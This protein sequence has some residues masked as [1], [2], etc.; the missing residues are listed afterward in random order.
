MPYTI[1]FE[2]HEG[3]IDEEPLSGDWKS[4]DDSIV[5]TNDVA[6]SGTQSVRIISANP[7]NI[8]SLR[9]DSSGS[10]IFFVDYYMQLTA[11][12][13]PVLPS[14]T[15]PETTAIIAVQPYLPDFGEWVFLDGDGDGRGVWRGSGEVMLLDG[16]GR[17]GWHRVTLRFNTTLNLW[18]AYVDG[19]LVAINLGFVETLSVGSEAINIYGNSIGVTYLDTFSL[20]TSNPL[21]TD[22][23]FDGIDDAF[24]MTH[25]LNNSEDDR[26]LDPDLDG[27]T[28]IEEYVYGIDPIVF[29][30]DEGVLNE[31]L[32]NR[33]AWYVD[34]VNGNDIKG[35]GS[36][37]YPFQTI[38]A[39][40]K[41]NV[42]HPDYL[43]NG[44]IIYLAGGNY[45]VGTLTEID[46]TGLSVEGT[47]DENGEPLTILGDVEISANNVTLKN[48][49]FHNS[50]LTLQS[51][52][53]AMIAN[54]VFSG[55]T[56]TSLSIF[57][58]S[59]NIISNNRFYSAI[60]SCV[61]IYWDSI[62]GN[63]SN[64]NQFIDNYFTNRP[65]ENTQQAIYVTWLSTDTNSISARNRFIN[66]AF[67]ETV[68]GRLGKVI[69]DSSTWW[70]V[71][72]YDYSIRFEDCYFK[73]ADRA[74]PFNEFVIIEDFPSFGWR[75]DELVNDAWVLS[76][77][78]YALTGNYN[79][80][81]HPPRVQ[82]TDS[83]GNGSIIET[84]HNAGLLPLVKTNNGPIISNPIV[85]LLIYQDSSSSTIDLY[86]VF[87]DI[88]TADS[89]LILTVSNSNQLL[90]DASI[91]N[92]I[93]TLNYVSGV[94]GS[95]TI[96]VT[97]TDGD[98][99]NPLSVSNTFKVEVAAKPVIQNRTDWY[100]DA[101]NGNDIYGTGDPS[102]PFQSL[103]HA[104][105]LNSQYPGFISAGDT[106]YLAPG[107]YGTSDNQNPITITFDTSD[108]SVQGTLDEFGKPLS[109]LSNVH[110]EAVANGFILANCEIL[111]GSLMLRNIEGAVI[112]NNSFT[113]TTPKWTLNTISDARSVALALLGA[114]NNTISNNQFSSATDTCVYL[115]WHDQDT[116]D[117]IGSDD[118]I[119]RF[120]YFTHH[121]NGTAEIIY[122]DWD[123]YGN[124]ASISN[125]NRFVE[126]AFE[127]SD[128]GL[129]TRVIHDTNYWWMG[130]TEGEFSLKF[131][132]CYFKRGDRSQAFSEFEIIVGRNDY[133][134]WDDLENDTWVS[135]NALAGNSS[136]VTALTG[137]YGNHEN[138]PRIRFVDG[139][140]DGL[141][142]AKS[143]L[144]G[145]VSPVEDSH[146]IDAL[147]PQPDFDLDGLK[148]N[149]D[150]DPKTALVWQ[151]PIITIN[152]AEFQIDNP[153]PHGVIA[154]AFNDNPI[155]LPG[156]AENHTSF[157]SGRVQGEGVQI[158]K[159][160]LFFNGYPVSEIFSK[161][162]DIVR[163]PTKFYSPDRT[164][165][166][167]SQTI[168]YGRHGT[169]AYDSEAV[170]TTDSS[171]LNQGYVEVGYGVL[172]S[173]SSF[174]ADYSTSSRIIYYG[175]K[176]YKLVGGGSITEY[177]YTYNRGG[178]LNTAGGPVEVGRGWI[179]SKNGFTPDTNIQSYKIYYGR[180]KFLKKTEPLYTSSPNRI[181]YVEVGRGWLTS[182]SG[183]IADVSGESRN[184]YYGAKD[185]GDVRVYLHTYN[186]SDLSSGGV[187]V[188]K[189]WLTSK[190]KFNADT[191]L[192][193]KRIYYGVRKFAHNKKEYLYTY[194]SLDV[195]GEISLGFGWLTS[196]NT[197]IPDTDKPSNRIYYTKYRHEYLYT[198]RRSGVEMGYGW[199][200]QNGFIADT[201][202]P[203]R[204]IYYGKAYFG[205][206][207]EYLY[208]PNPTDIVAEV[209][210]GRGWLTSKNRF[211]ADYSADPREVYY[212]M[213]SFGHYSRSLY[214]YNRHAFDDVAL[215][216][217]GWIESVNR[218]LNVD[219]ASSGEIDSD[220][221]GL[222]DVLEMQIGTSTT[223]SDT[224]FDG[225]SDS[226]EVNNY[227]TDPL[228]WDT[229][230][231]LLSDG[232]EA[233][234]SC[235]NPLAYDDPYALDST[236][237]LTL[238]KATQF[239]FDICNGDTDV[240][241][242]QLNDVL[243][244]TVYGT[245]VGDP[246]TDK[247]GLLDGV[248]LTY[249]LNP[250]IDDSMFDL[251]GDGY[252]N[253]FE[254][255]GVNGD[256]RD[257]AITPET[258]YLVSVD[259]SNGYGSIQAAIDDVTENYSII[260][261]KPGMYTGSGNFDFSIASDRPAVL[262]IAEEGAATTVLDGGQT[263]P[264]PSIFN[265][266]SAIVGFTIRNGAG[267]LDGGGLFIG[268]DHTSVAKCEIYGNSTIRNGA[269]I[270]VDASNVRI[271]NT[272]IY[273]NI[274]GSNGGGIYAN[275]RTSMEI[276]H[277]TVYNNTAPLGSEIYIS[278][279]PANDISMVNSIVW[280]ESVDAKVISGDI[281]S[282]S[283][284]IIK[285]TTGY[286]VND[287]WIINDDPLLTLEGRLN[288]DSI[289]IDRVLGSVS[290]DVD[291]QIRPYG[292]A[293]DI[294]AD[295][296]TGTVYGDGDTDSD[297]LRDWWE[298]F[299]FPG[300]DISSISPT[301]DPDKDGLV[302]RDELYLFSLPNLDDT[303]G[304]G[305][306]DGDEINRYG[307]D[308][309]STD[310]DGDSLSDGWEVTYGFNPGV[311]NPADADSDNDG[312]ADR[313][314]FQAGGNPLVEDT[315]GDGMSDRFE[316]E[317]GLNLALDDRELDKDNDGLSN[318][319]EFIT[320]T[321]A[322]YFDSDG[323]LLSDGWEVEHGLD[324]LIANDISADNDGDGID[325][326][327]EYQFG[328]NP[329]ASDTDG[330][331][332]SDGVEISQGSNANG[333]GDS[334]QAP[335]EDNLQEV[336]FSVGDPS[337]S[338]SERWEMNIQGLGP[339]TRQLKFSNREFGILG[340]N[341]FKLWK[342]TNYHITLTHIGSKGEQ[343]DYDWEAT[344]EG[345]PNTTVLGNSGTNSGSDRFTLVGNWIIDNKSGLLGV[346][347]QGFGS[348]NFAEGKEA[349]LLKVDLDIVHP[350]SGELEESKEDTNDGGYV[351]IKREVDGVDVAPVTHLKLHGNSLL[352]SDTKFRL[353]FADS[354]R[355]K[356]YS[357]AGRSTEIVSEQTE[358]AT[359]TD[360]TLY[361][362]G[363]GKSQSRGGEKLT[364]QIGING[365]WY[366][367]DTVKCTVVQSEFDIVNRVFIPYNWV[368]VPHPAH[369]IHVAEGDDRGYDPQLQGTFRVEQTVIICP[370]E[371][372]SSNRYKSVQATP[373]ITRHFYNSDVVNHT[374]AT[375]SGLEPVQPSYIMPGATVADGEEA[376]A[377]VS[378]V[379]VHLLPDSTSSNQTFVE[380]RGSAKE[381]IVAFAAPIDWRFNIG[382]N[383]NDP[384]NPKY[385]FSGIHDG[386]PAYE[387]Y[388]N[389]RLENFPVTEVLQWSPTLDKGVLELL[390]D[391]DTL[392]DT[393]GFTDIE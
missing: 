53:G 294:G 282:V 305:L 61:Y 116:G 289:A 371:D 291:G 347:N 302:N 13:L 88:E 121:F 68:S 380:L 128:R 285:G 4:T 159:Y 83:N 157:V 370:Y 241:D 259:S 251:D 6:H 101:T 313:F 383:I 43:N 286:S 284:C 9:F 275:D 217:T 299:Y 390:G 163:K 230:N 297:G 114:S 363:L 49:E 96:R 317:N 77:Y 365:N 102:L 108:L 320:G 142:L 374:G 377:D 64:D 50:D 366:D 388:I 98:A 52:T 237:G 32:Y 123:K 240:D 35:V 15:D 312:V 272:I 287:G 92:G 71:D 196:K 89:D 132:D 34:V 348:E 210:V 261:V 277:N 33:T 274:A 143:H 119:F 125:R 249:G 316:Y 262:V 298:T 310:S 149:F 63:T 345:L 301:D 356:I 184:I 66:C 392:T 271:E 18:D 379:T 23:D 247:D 239:G 269:G 95:A 252:P 369:A 161:S 41:L 304:D 243:E 73:R 117:D 129:L 246:D 329:F 144:A 226:E 72:A 59:N 227:K 192:K 65:S 311:G 238:L 120:N 167:G 314:E 343:P 174:T 28:N 152:G 165:L 182:K 181:N 86:D 229:D 26:N 122:V 45:D 333:S 79:D 389:G 361:F 283:N 29:N 391:A 30:A 335:S 386:F 124:L 322:N 303:D 168:Y 208:T 173:E 100:I 211:A 323:D 288:A 199:I 130:N 160:Q 106:I 85:D 250:L 177:I 256:V 16:L 307:T 10:T 376:Q 75:W 164:P 233:G 60:Y 110:I 337:G 278:A 207:I 235:L 135:E 315:D 21:F 326:F 118:N 384:I 306:N 93:L 255:K 276:V 309:L 382:I 148:D 42:N 321:Q 187:L 378:K 265:S 353:K 146:L 76:N 257:R 140:A 5:T 212:G 3:F 154:Y 295:E 70:M 193:S 364:M 224:D 78:Q 40:L 221:D 51:A 80:W 172:N 381:P 358:F 266:G 232:I 166:E 234:Y 37:E 368:N 113:G 90:V 151:D 279:N 267:N 153:N 253:I 155:Q 19:S 260:L 367:G 134:K 331:G 215:V 189:G 372:L 94:T 38:N 7:E 197:F 308:L 14:F 150:S 325:T 25:G 203:S 244:V 349:L 264:G 112:F 245:T 357:D 360:N 281:V 351:S 290:A 280:N 131:E 220:G 145:L 67:E 31:I 74:T 104:L 201:N 195:G 293:A 205:S 141:V 270:Y 105:S 175:E 103:Q 183:F 194:D 56:D 328:T 82:F 69:Q 176:I 171:I 185:F 180:K 332:T 55:T 48:I 236:T 344:I 198:H 258:T 99:A 22:L 263:Y 156:A 24:E 327:N 355:Y 186:E 190:E 346:V 213:Y 1:D 44:D 81:N 202:R 158:L 46:I 373:G 11:S 385:A 218:W 12:A 352:P 362:Q 179:N 39:V 248:E 273:G 330:D 162:I 87:E 8:I 126:C 219:G 342:D 178:L 334:G 27:L 137:Y 200:T 393:I 336:S 387:V 225:A 296:A 359:N 254:I 58:S 338:H 222:I 292:G 318:Y 109:V 204:K 97:A 206:H 339:D 169:S 350:V 319:E 20:T 188:G 375:H 354:S 223:L 216:G 214:S 91:K 228:N 111:N 209:E 57:G 324:P 54:N 147:S 231:D 133:W 268:G 84:N 17:T 107:D 300:T 36:S 62:S 115:G 242:D 341:V 170:Y 127:E 139:D 47:L 136:Q 191:N 340:T 2:S 138:L